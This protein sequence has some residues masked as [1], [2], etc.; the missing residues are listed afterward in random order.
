FT[1]TISNIDHEDNEVQDVIP[2]YSNVI[3]INCLNF[4]EFEESFMKI[5][6][7]P[8]W[9]PH[10][11]IILHFHSILDD[12][13]KAKIFFIMWYYKAANAVIIYYDDDKELLFVTDY[14]P[15]VYENYTLPF[16]FGCWTAKKIGIAIEN[17]ANGFM[18]EDSC[19][20][21]SLHSKLRGNNL[22]TCIGFDTKSVSYDDYYKKSKRHLN[23]FKP[24]GKHLHGYTLRAYTTEVK[25]FLTIKD[26]GDDTYTIGARDGNIWNTMAKLMNF[27][28]DVTPSK[29]V[30]MLPFNFEVN[31]Q[32]IFSFSHRKADLFLI[33]IYQI[34]LIIVQLD[35]TFAFKDSGVCL[36]AH[37][38]DFE[39]ELFDIK[40]LQ[41]N[42]DLLIK[43][44]FTF[45]G[46]WMAFS[47]F[48]YVE[49]GKID[50]DQVGKDLLNTVRNTLTISLYR[51]PKKGSFRIFLVLTL[52]SYFVLNFASQA[53]ITSFFS[54]KKKGKEMETFEDIIE[55]G[56]N[57]EGMASPDVV[58]PETEERFQK[59]NSKLVPVPNLF[60]C[61]D[62]MK[63]DSK[64]FCLIDCAVGRYLERNALDFKGQQFLHIAKDRIHSHYLNM[65]FPKHSPMTEHF[66]K[67]MIA[68]VEAG[69]IK[70]WEEFRFSDIKEE[71]PIKPLQM[72][73]LMSVFD[74]YFMLIALSFMTFSLELLFSLSHFVGNLSGRSFVSVTSS[75]SV[76]SASRP[77]SRVS[78]R[79]WNDS[80]LQN[81]LEASKTAWPVAHK[82]SIFLPEFPITTDLLQKNFEIT[83]TIAKG[84]FGQ[85]YK[86]NKVTENRDYALKVL[87]KGQVVSENAVRQV[88]E[89]ARIQE[90]CGHH[91]FIAGSVS[92]WQT[93]K[94]LYIVS[95]Y[96]PCGELLALL[97][98]YH[99]IPEELVK[100]LIAE[101]ASAI[102]FLHNAGVIYRDLKPE[103]ILLDQNYHIKL[104]DFGLSK[105][106]SIGSRTTT[107]CG[108]LQYMGK[109]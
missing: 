9:H 63:N 50:V 98:R 48:N 30:M 10:G 96:I 69:I 32:Q 4:E 43:F 36:A 84:A 78:R 49:K 19:Y 82:E 89:E 85:V 26:N 24:K 14:D 83:Q 35:Q 22:G 105:W 91:S 76:Y 55:K 47:V 57:I 72:E 58:L 52:W 20:N 1:Y 103:N 93:K 38:A 101:I 39:T 28:I 65:I 17:F 70:K 54:A 37:R 44:V 6:G 21:V 99:I 79:R 13:T 64:R 12:E 100:I 71:A 2:Y 61:I 27:T 7:F 45:I 87:N 81:P 46:S 109:L 94:R 18:C 23:M 29:K 68:L 80:T 107:L 42:Y 62:R 56:Y 33:P 67:Y 90:A 104:I 102:D 15:Y 92:R 5:L 41:T 74:C 11:N 25:P 66:N 53:A 8:Y 16:E 3:V 86:V 88:K 34:D 51:P 75:Q 60:A 95:E 31:I 97:E 108:T 106:L 77:W 73:D 59:I 40:L